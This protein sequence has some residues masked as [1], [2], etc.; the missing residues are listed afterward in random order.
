MLHFKLANASALR[1]R[2]WHD[3]WPKWAQG[4]QRARN[5]QRRLPARL[6]AADLQVEGPLPFEDDCIS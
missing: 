1:M 5:G 3:D 2:T 6:A 4:V